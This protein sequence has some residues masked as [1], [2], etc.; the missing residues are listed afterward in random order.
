MHQHRSQQQPVESPHESTLIARVI[1][2]WLCS[3]IAGVLLL[4][5]A[6]AHSIAFGWIAYWLVGAPLLMW[7]MQHRQRLAARA[8]T[9]LVGLF[10][11]RRSDMSGA[12]NPFNRRQGWLH[13]R[14]RAQA[15]RI[16]LSR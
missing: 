15:R 14:P 13:G 8:Q 11:R 7:A 12:G 9:V 6:R 2:I 4:P 10:L 5:T 3:G 16:A 1:E